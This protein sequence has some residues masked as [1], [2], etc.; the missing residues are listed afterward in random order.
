MLEWYRGPGTL[1]DILDDTVGVVR[2]VAAALVDIGV[3]LDAG[4]VDFFAPPT[5]VACSDAF[6]AAGVDL[7]AAIDETRAGQ[8]DALPRRV[9][10]TGEF[11]PGSPGFDDAFFHVMGARVEPSIGHD[12][13]AVVERWPASMAVLARVDDDDPRFARRVEIYAQARG[14]CLELCNAFDELTDAV[15][16]RARFEMDVRERVQLGKAPL[17]I[18][19]DFLAALPSMPSPSAGNALGFDRLLML[20]TGAPSIDDVTAQPWR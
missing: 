8:H 6:A 7:G 4:A 9:R 5:R 14:G 13:L 17:P 1:D 18:D 19:E 15:E 12:R 2:A 11:L 20:L 10:A 16:Q 3:A